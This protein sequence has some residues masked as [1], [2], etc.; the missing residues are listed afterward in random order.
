MLPGRK[1]GPEREQFVLS[2]ADPGPLPANDDDIAFAPLTKLSRWV[3][4][5]KLSSE[6]LTTLYLER[7]ERFNPTLRCVIT[8][9][10]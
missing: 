6:R 9:T 10:P 3:E 7:L 2:K 4:L 1:A 5:R 8:L